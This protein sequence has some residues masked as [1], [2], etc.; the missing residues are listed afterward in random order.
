MKK[1]KYS[2]LQ[3]NYDCQTLF[4][5]AIGLQKSPIIAAEFIPF[6]SLFC[7]EAL[8]YLKK[9]KISLNIP[10][11]KSFSV[12]DIRLKTKLFEDKYS[13]AKKMILN[14]DYL[15]DY[16]FKH[17]LRFRFMQDWNVHYNLGIFTDRED[18]IVGNS[19]YGYYIYQDNRLLKKCISE[20][21]SKKIIN[22]EV[23]P[24]ECY[25][26]GY[27][28]GQIVGMLLSQFSKTYP[29]KL[30][31]CKN[32]KY[33]LFYQDYNTNKHFSAF[34]QDE[35]GKALTLYLLHILSF[36]NSTLKLFSAFEEDDYGWWLRMYYITYYYTVKR[37]KDIKNHLNQLQLMNDRINRFYNVLNLEDNDIFN[38]DFRSCM[39]HY[40]MLNKENVCLI[41]PEYEDANIPLF[42]LVESCFDGMTY[43]ELKKQ[44]VKEL[45]NISEVIFKWL[46][47]KVTKPKKF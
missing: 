32:I 1:K 7:S 29:V 13:K 26:Y 41:L 12:E 38:F 6:L 31:R 42:G 20:A 36:V 34:Y 22:Y 30:I 39:M 5:L 46:G 9:Y 45:E 16:I 2:L 28:C 25:D 19:Q 8:K 33:D 10:K 21:K 47:I 18:N 35:D 44:V 40:D 43:Y 17:K 27:Y 23:I 14:C 37:L 3:I 24:K 4:S 15:Q 11:N